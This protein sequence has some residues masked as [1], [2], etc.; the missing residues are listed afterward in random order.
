MFEFIIW[1]SQSGSL[2]SRDAVGPQHVLFCGCRNSMLLRIENYF[3]KWNLKVTLG[4]LIVLML[5]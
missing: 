2:V 3:R 1:W 5:H 4:L